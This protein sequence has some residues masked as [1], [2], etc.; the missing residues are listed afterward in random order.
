MPFSTFFNFQKE[1]LKPEDADKG[2]RDLQSFLWKFKISPKLLPLDYFF[3]TAHIVPLQRRLL[4][5]SSLNLICAI[6]SSDAIER[7]SLYIEHS[8]KRIAMAEQNGLDWNCTFWKLCPPVSDANFTDQL[9]STLPFVRI[10]LAQNF[11]KREKFAH[12]LPPG[13]GAGYWTG[14]AV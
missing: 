14:F 11:A 13:R 5:P 12:I 4:T 6:R 10:L 3:K 8:E 9:F 1:V 7:W 2:G